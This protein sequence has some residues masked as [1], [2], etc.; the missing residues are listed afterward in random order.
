[1]KYPS[2]AHRRV[3]KILG[4]VIAASVL[5][6]LLP[7]R[8]TSAEAGAPAATQPAPAPPASPEAW[9][10]LMRQ[11][12][13]PKKGCFKASFPNTTW[14]EV[15]C[16]T[17][18]PIPYPPARGPHSDKV[19]DKVG[20]TARRFIPEVGAEVSY[21]ISEA[22]GSFDSVT[23]VTSEKGTDGGANAFSLQLNSNFFDSPACA[24]AASRKC[25]G[26][27]QFVYSNVQSHMVFMQYW[28]LDYGRKCPPHWLTSGK[29]CFANSAAAD[30]PPQT[31][32]Q[33]GELGVKGAATEGGMD[34][35]ILGTGSEL[36]SAS[37]EDSVLDL[38]QAWTMAE[39]NVVGDCCRSQADFNKGSTIVISTGVDDGVVKA[40]ACRA[41][42]FTGE[43]NNLNLVR[44]SDI[45]PGGPLP[46]IVF[47]ESNAAGPHRGDAFCTSA[48]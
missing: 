41:E 33:L 27:Q 26:W 1:M 47:T 17:A 4:I 24:A 25:K 5:S 13:L 10:A 6:G 40:P 43:T 34:M 39:F 37:G 32:A 19:G 36:Y 38:A 28:L 46:E 44:F 20:E 42:G 3:A 31:I 11:V 30:V 35:V 48:P 22:V 15:P 9:R 29:D 18:P 12:P 21:P 8:A 45:L 7:S 23:G 16:T 14:Q 2:S